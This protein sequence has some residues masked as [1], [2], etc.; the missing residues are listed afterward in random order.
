MSVFLN[1]KFTREKR[2]RIM[3]FLLYDGSHTNCKQNEI[4]RNTS[5]PLE[6]FEIMNIYFQMKILDPQ[7]YFLKKLLEDLFD[8]LLSKRN[9]E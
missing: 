8:L 6:R 1:F 3:S 5:Q 4:R 2:T 7:I 9:C